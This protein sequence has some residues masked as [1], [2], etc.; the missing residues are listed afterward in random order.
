MGLKAVGAGLFLEMVPKTQPLAWVV[1]TSAGAT[2]VA[3]LGPKHYWQ[4]ENGRVR[5]RESGACVNVI[6]G[7]ASGG[8][9]VAVRGHGNEPRKRFASSA[10][11]PS[12][13]FAWAAVSAAELA[14]DA[15]RV[16][17]VATAEV[18]SEGA[19]LAAIAAFPASRE[20][21]VVSYGL[22]GANPKYTLG[23]VRNAELVHVYF[24]GWVCTIYEHVCRIVGHA[25]ACVY[26]LP[27]Y[28]YTRPHALIGM[29]VFPS[30]L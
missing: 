27:G 15:Q 25:R 30:L 24:P 9:T 12:T 18:H 28:G 7:G 6:G 14:A 5:N 10:D 2:S 22:Y 20:K 8:G 23:A 13:L 4:L 11:E 29:L 3:G 21:R 19:Y 1:R 16:A 17:V 26:T